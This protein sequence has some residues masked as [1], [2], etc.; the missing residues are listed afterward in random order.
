MFSKVYIFWQICLS[1]FTT[2]NLNIYILSV[3]NDAHLKWLLRSR[4]HEAVMSYDMTS[5]KLHSWICLI[6]HIAN[7]ITIPICDMCSHWTSKRTPIGVIS[8]DFSH[9]N[10]TKQLFSLPDL[11]GYGLIQRSPKPSGWSLPRPTP[12]WP[13]TSWLAPRTLLRPSRAPGRSS[14]AETP[15]SGH[16]LCA[17][18]RRAELAPSLSAVLSDHFL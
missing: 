10:G 16:C 4:L 6:N 15:V 12:R 17:C 8:K 13:R 18:H 9:T 7:A 5:C 11:R 14:S 2:L 1:I 3:Q